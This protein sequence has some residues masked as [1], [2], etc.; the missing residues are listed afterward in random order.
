MLYNKGMTKVYSKLVN[1]IDKKPK[2]MKIAFRL[3]VDSQHKNKV[4]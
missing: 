3:K 4:N 2:L 1:M